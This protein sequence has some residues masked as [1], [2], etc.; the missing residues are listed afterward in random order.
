M[1]TSS[2]DVLG[3]I[4]A[5]KRDVVAAARSQA[6]LAELQARIAG[7]PA[8]VP[9]AETLRRTGP[10]PR[11]I[12]EIKRASPSKGPLR[13]DLDP[14][15]IAVAYARAGA[16]AISVLTEERWFQ[17]SLSDLAAVRRAVSLPLLRKD[18][19]VDPYQLFEARAHGADAVLLIV[20]ALEPSQLRELHEQAVAL[21]L[22]VLVEVHTDDEAD[23]ARALGARVVGV[24][25]RDLR[26]LTM[27]AG[28]FE[29]VRP[30]LGDD[31]IAVAESGI[32]G[33]ADAAR[34]VAA[35]A[36]AILVGET[37]MR[38]DDIGRALA[39]LTGTP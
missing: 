6:P 36:D 7:L 37:L 19:V 20:A 2:K 29:S 10:A 31:V 38:A 27:H 1:S 35:G 5:H 21:G 30:R 18:F 13:P 11:V 33:P 25:H 8:A 23:V 39:A 17:G 14:A 34:L 3:T 26:T 24:N 22:G 12:A 16:A 28:R 4:C 15:Q 32:A 9:F